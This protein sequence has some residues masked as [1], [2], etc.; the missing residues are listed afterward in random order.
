VERSGLGRSLSIGEFVCFAL[1][2]TTFIW[3][4]TRSNSTS[5]LSAVQNKEENV[6]L[7][8]CNPN[9]SLLT[10]SLLPPVV[11]VLPFN[12]HS[13]LFRRV[14]KLLLSSLESGRTCLVDVII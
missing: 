14:D 12:A 7:T 13:L 6:F 5:G 9:H 1:S 10:P 2:T 8:I 4:D 3:F 11:R